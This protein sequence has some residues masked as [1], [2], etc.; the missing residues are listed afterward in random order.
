MLCVHNQDF[1]AWL[2]DVEKEAR[3]TYMRRRGWQTN[4]NRSVTACYYCHRGGAYTSNA[5][6]KQTK[7][8]VQFVPSINSTI[9]QDPLNICK[10]I[11]VVMCADIYSMIFY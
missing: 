2:S 11:L 10:I 4:K 9:E 5:T 7:A 3:C 1:K 6:K 8:Q